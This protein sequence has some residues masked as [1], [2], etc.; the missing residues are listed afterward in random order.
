VLI[1][2]AAR[3]EEEAACRAQLL[4]EDEGDDAYQFSHDVIREVVEADVGQHGAS[5]RIV[6][7]AQRLG[8]REHAKRVEQAIV[9]APSFTIV[10]S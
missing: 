1:G 7:H 3:P 5:S 10:T 6:A 8:A 4:V 9:G 2:T